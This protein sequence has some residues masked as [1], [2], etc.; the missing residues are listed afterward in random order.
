M[1]LDNVVS[2]H[3][4]FDKRRSCSSD[5]PNLDEQRTLNVIQKQ[6]RMAG[7]TLGCTLNPIYANRSKQLLSIAAASS[8]QHVRGL[9]ACLFYAKTDE[10]LGVQIAAYP[11]IDGSIWNRGLQLGIIANAEQLSGMQ[12]GAYTI[13]SEV[14]MQLGLI[15]RSYESKVQVGVVNT[16]GA[17]SY[18]PPSRQKTSAHAQNDKKKKGIL[19]R[20]PALQ[21]GLS[22]TIDGN[23]DRDVLSVGLY[24]RRIEYVSQNNGL[25]TKAKH[26][27]L[28]IAYTRK[29]A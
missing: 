15:T 26:W 1:P 29:E 3:S 20:L 5:A 6:P 4:A 9:Q 18:D 10:L 22:N 24:N 13:A 23:L 16:I 17:G 21:I 27:L 25:K 7:E 12:I 14:T 11:N 8:A 19:S 28:P 2:Q